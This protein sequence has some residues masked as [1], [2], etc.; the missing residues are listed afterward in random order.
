MSFVRTLSLSVASVICLGV[1]T[2]CAARAEQATLDRMITMTPDELEWFEPA[3]LPAGAEMTVI[4]GPMDEDRPFTAR[5]RFPAGY[6]LPAHWHPAVERV[7]VLEGT[8]NMGMGDELD[9]T[10]TQPLGPGAVKMIPI[11]MRHFA[12]TDEETVIQLHGH[13]PW[14]IVYVDPANDPRS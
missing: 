11:G 10:Q 1:L 2:A 7:T 3:S 5:I 4:E 13:G 12:W 9:R 8:F 6:E 14:G